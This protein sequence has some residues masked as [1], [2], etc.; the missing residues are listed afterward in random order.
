M[1]RLQNIETLALLLGV[2]IMM[3]YLCSAKPILSSLSMEDIN[4]MSSSIA[5]DF[6]QMN[7]TE[8][9][10]TTTT[11]SLVVPHIPTKFYENNPTT[12][13]EITK[14]YQSQKNKKFKKILMNDTQRIL[15]RTDRSVDL[16]ILNNSLSGVKRVKNFHKASILERNER[17]TNL[18]HIAGSTRRIQLYIKNRFLQILNDGTVNGTTDDNSEYS[19]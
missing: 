6:N 2:L 13:V 18:S 19:K 17:S 12:N 7:S 11:K 16:I 3:T 10:T 4:K 1:R 9:I 8:K 15:S 14:F 5:V